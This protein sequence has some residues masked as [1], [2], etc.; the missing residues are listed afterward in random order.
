[1]Y[2]YA[3]VSHASKL[4][5]PS[6]MPLDVCLGNTGVDALHSLYIK[7][8]AACHV[9]PFA[10]LVS[11][12][13]WSLP[14]RPTTR[15]MQVVKQLFLQCSTLRALQKSCN[16]NNDPQQPHRDIRNCRADL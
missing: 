14:T 5:K 16:C 11:N 15:V 4:L 6:F 12:C 13:R 2:A 9:M 10:Q 3:S 8:V 1:M 7:T